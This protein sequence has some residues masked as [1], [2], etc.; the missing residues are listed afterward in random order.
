[1]IFSYIDHD[2]Y[3]DRGD[4]MHFQREFANVTIFWLK[5]YISLPLVFTYVPARLF[6]FIITYAYLGTAVYLQIFPLS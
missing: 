6:T 1:M 4:S 3:L 5:Q 2:L